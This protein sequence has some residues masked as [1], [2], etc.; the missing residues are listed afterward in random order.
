MVENRQQAVTSVEETSM[1]SPAKS[2]NKHSQNV[3][4]NVVQMTKQDVLPTV[5]VLPT[6]CVLPAGCTAYGVCTTYGVRTTYAVR[7]AYGVRT[8]KGV[9]A[10]LCYW[11]LIIVSCGK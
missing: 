11:P 5:C 10:R 1:N 8:V 4:S 2:I 9:H 7:T 3:L 6:M